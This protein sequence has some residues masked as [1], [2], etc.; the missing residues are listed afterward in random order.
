M[1]YKFS[2]LS[3]I[4]TKIFVELVRTCALKWNKTDY[5]GLGVKATVVMTR[6][7]GQVETVWESSC[8]EAVQ[9]HHVFGLNKRH[10]PGEEITQNTNP[11]N[12]WYERLLM[13][14]PCMPCCIFPI[15]KLHTPGPI[16]P[17]QPA[18]LSGALAKNGGIRDTQLPVSLPTHIYLPVMVITPCKLMTLRVV[19]NLPGRSG[20]CCRMSV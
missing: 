4:G 17:T 9:W 10:Q 11:M 3:I 6:T 7:E 18:V 12:M 15:K 19:S 16:P 5:N 8:T 20:S 14:H 1:Y 13:G 2:S